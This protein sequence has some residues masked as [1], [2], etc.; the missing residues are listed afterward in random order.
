MKGG[1]GTWA[2]RGGLIVGALAVVNAYGDGDLRAGRWRAPATAAGLPTLARAGGRWVPASRFGPTPPSWPNAALD[3]PVL[4]DAAVPRRTR[5]WRIRPVGTAVDGD[6]VRCFGWR[7]GQP[8][9]AT[10][11]LL[12]QDALT[13]AIERA[14]TKARG[15]GG[16]PGLAD[17][18]FG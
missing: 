3:R 8:E 10:V 11:E 15:L 5:F 9:P 16:V 14:V 2:E 7:G 13:V 6:A 12:A 1:V 17:R 18:S 4:A